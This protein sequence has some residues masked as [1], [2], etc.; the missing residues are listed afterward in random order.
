MNKQLYYFENGS[1]YPYSPQLPAF[2]PQQ[3]NPYQVSPLGLPL[4]T[5]LGAQQVPQTPAPQA[6]I[7]TPEANF[8]RSFMQSYVPPAAP[9]PMEGMDLNFSKTEPTPEMI[10]D[11]DFDK[12]SAE[13]IAALDPNNK[14]KQQNGYNPYAMWGYPYYGTQ[15]FNQKLGAAL[16]FKPQ[17]NENPN[18]SLAGQK[19]LKG[20]QIGTSALGSLLGNARE[21]FGAYAASKRQQYLMGRDAERRREALLNDPQGQEE[22]FNNGWQQRGILGFIE[23][24]GQK[25]KV[26]QV[27]QY[28][29]G[30]ENK[31]PIERLLTDATTGV[32]QIDY[33]KGKHPEVNS[34]VEVGEFILYPDGSIAEVDGKSHSNGGEKINLPEGAKIISDNVLVSKEDS[35]KYKK[36]GFDVTINQTYADAYRK[37]RKKAGITKLNEEQQDRYKQLEKNDKIQDD[38]TKKVNEEHLSEKIYNIERKKEK[39]SPIENYFAD[40]TYN[41]QEDTKKSPNVRK[42]NNNSYQSDFDGKHIFCDGGKMKIPVVYKDGGFYTTD[43]KHILPFKQWVATKGFKS[44]DELNNYLFEMGGM[45]EEGKKYANEDGGQIEN[46]I[47]QM[48]QQGIT[49]EKI[50]EQLIQAGYDMATAQATVEGVMQQVQD[51]MKDGG[52]KKKK[53]LNYYED[54]GLSED[55]LDKYVEKLIEFE[56]TR[57]S[58]E[59]KGLDISQFTG[60]KAKDRVDLRMLVEDVYLKAIKDELG[61]N[62][63]KLD[64]QILIELLDYKFNTGRNVGDLLNYAE[65]K[66]TID[67]INSNKSFGVP[68]VVNVDINALRQAK[69][70]I[71][72]T[73]KGGTVDKPT[74]AYNNS[75]QGRVG[76]LDNLFADNN[77]SSGSYNSNLD[78]ESEAESA[79]PNLAPLPMRT[80]SKTTS[81]GATAGTKGTPKIDSEGNVVFGIPG[82]EFTDE[83]TKGTTVPVQHARKGSKGLYGIGTGTVDNLIANNPW[84]FD[85]DTKKQWEDTADF[86]SPEGEKTVLEFQKAYND[87]LR[88]E[89]VKAGQ[90]PN[91]WVERYGFSED[92]AATARQFDGKLG[93]FTLSRKIPTFRKTEGEAAKPKDETTTTVDE[94]YKPIGSATGGFGFYDE[95]PYVQTPWMRSLPPFATPQ[96]QRISPVKVSP[97]QAIAEASRQGRLASE[98]T[99]L[100]A[101]RAAN[102]ANI[103]RIT[104]DISAD[105]VAN[106][107]KQNAMLKLQV[108]QFNAGQQGREEEGRINAIARY[109]PDAQNRLMLNHEDW[110]S[111][112][113][114]RYEN[115]QNVLKEARQRQIYQSMSPNYVYDPF[116]NI[117]VNPNAEVPLAEPNFGSMYGNGQ[118]NQAPQKQKFDPNEYNNWLQYQAFLNQQKN[119]S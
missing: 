117:M 11:T 54:G 65:G 59:G 115:R 39:L 106:A 4:D 94:T 20:I 16:A 13:V 56:G 47:A 86:N 83:G 81:T 34:E 7:N 26:A 112:Y 108:D 25:G 5:G 107:E 79:S 31:V 40:L 2:V 61:D 113:Q 22:L 70:D 64:R 87:Q 99:E 24:G 91:Y 68:D 102:L 8:K 36:M 3:P 58:A 53:G 118:F 62:Y 97:E 84:Y 28:E 27:R 95:L 80:P 96:Y 37:I 23:D 30:G 110:G 12:K 6:A 116:G 104:S 105:A 69:D 15:T 75:W 100:G 33:E 49:P 78:N 44:N 14:Q 35:K 18:F 76:Y 89:A 42:E 50:I 17:V 46:S 55:D 45:K 67:E 66:L 103:Q 72:R 51:M 41:W 93:D 71:Y 73:T 119:A 114:Q 43:V 74:D 19:A 92:K 101:G 38:T 21:V 10:G 77:I 98:S 48:L 85:E 88:A 90:D 111:Y 29:N 32:S 63:N 9:D 60:G 109:E 82:A 1:F 52:K 57:G